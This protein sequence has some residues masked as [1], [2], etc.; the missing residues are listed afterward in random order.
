MD[1]GGWGP[2][3]PGEELGCGRHGKGGERCR[4]CGAGAAGLRPAPA[5]SLSDQGTASLP[6][7]SPA[8]LPAQS[9]PGGSRGSRQAVPPPPESVFSSRGAWSWSTLFF[10]SSYQVERVKRAV[11]REK[12]VISVPEGGVLAQ[13]LSQACSA[14]PAETSLLLRALCRREEGAGVLLG[15]ECS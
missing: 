8:S 9:C 13:S 6:A 10:R 4:R 3:Q 1:F 7:A 11:E 14:V 12:E 2:L 5:P 15:W